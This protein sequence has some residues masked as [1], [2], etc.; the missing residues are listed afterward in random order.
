MKRMH[1][2]P[3]GAELGPDGGTRFRLWAPSARGVELVLAPGEARETRQPLTRDAQ[4]WYECL[5][6][7]APAGTR[8]CYRVNHE[9]DVADPASRFN[10]LGV[11][12][13]SEVV[14]PIAFDW[15]DGGW[16]GRAWSQAVIY[17]L[18]VGTFTPQG[19]FRAVEARLAKLA[20]L[21]VT[22]LEL[23]PVA[24]FPG[25]RNWG[26]DGVLPFAPA[27]V[28]GRP[29]DLKHLVDAA[30]AR[31]LMVLLDVVYNHFGPDGNY[32]GAYA[33]TFFTNRHR[34]PWGQAIN[35]GGADARCVRDFF[36]HNA[37]YW[38]EEFHFDGLRV[39][40]VHAIRDDSPRHF[41]D[42][43]VETV[44]SGPGRERHVHVVLENH[45]N[46][47][48]FLRNAAAAS[49]GS[50]SQWNDD[51]HHALH[52]LATGESD[53][54]YADYADAPLHHL[55]RCLAEGFSYQGEVPPRSGARARGEPSRHLPPTAFVNFLQTHDQVGNRA[56]GERL[57]RLADRAALR[58]ALAV[59]L[60]APQPPLLFMG[61]EYAAPQ[62]FLYFCDFAS[63]LAA[64]VTAGRRREFA[65][66][67]AFGDEA[68][69]NSIPDPCDVRTFRASRLRWSE[70]R[71]EPCR[72]WL[73]Y[74]RGLLVLRA[75]EIVALVPR[76]VPGQARYEVRASG[77]LSVVWPVNDGGVLCMEA[78]LSG[79]ALQPRSGSEALPPRAADRA[80]LR[81]FFPAALAEPHLEDG[82]AAWQV[83]WL[84]TRESTS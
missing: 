51:F 6:S 40:A 27:S 63:E 50:V 47:A 23:M 81:Q 28:Y 62:P 26:Y 2:M 82:L 36:L 73:Q 76:L 79:R 56:L 48:R 74:V 39:D 78:N 31:G 77:A 11:H 80:R 84:R 68:T 38:L 41:V 10:P 64:A 4:G 46:N 13:A 69:R 25:T 3:F 53:G 21:G 49:R 67:A 71:Q 9:L 52:V 43:L 70:R 5:R 33:A 7:D 65:A 17:E 54:Y 24:A 55:G 8:Y 34:T 14:D 35:L 15:Q 19:T 30:H 37:L 42:E 29:E 60:L 66:F 57:G 16:S 22:A 75:R 1:P 58:A 83:R 12:A 61:E 44:Q 18:H 59:L 20:A 45:S 72:G 32:L